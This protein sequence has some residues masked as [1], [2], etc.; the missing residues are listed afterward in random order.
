MSGKALADGTIVV[1]DVGT[2]G[3]AQDVLD[4]SFRRPVVVDFWAPWCGPCRV[5][6]PVLEQLA[7]D[8]G[9]RWLL[10]KLNT[11]ENQDLSAQFGI[12]GIP[13]VKA[14][15]Q[16][17]VVEEFVGAL[18]RA[19]VQR[20]LE[21]FVRGAADEKADEADRALAAGD[22]A[23]A[24]LLYKEALQAK[25]R[26]G[27]AQLGLARVCFAESDWDGATDAL[28]DLALMEPDA[29]SQEISALRLQIDAQRGGGL[30]AAKREAAQ[31]ADD[32]EAQV[33]LAKALA[34]SGK[35]E[36][37]LALFLSVIQKQRSGPGE[38]ARQGMVEVFGV[39]GMRHPLSEKYRAELAQI[40][41]S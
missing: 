13:A 23:T 33:R 5:L 22:P 39:L 21:R 6:G 11:D 36:E 4:E 12:R 8:F 25:P 32:P 18:P 15:V 20:W 9:G 2:N 35:H 14:F 29:F 10:A 19:E 7:S 38:E 17:E 26:M 28:E 24:R 3:F 40:L 37:A 30:E 31:H 41:H 1:K 27:R 34:A 16:G